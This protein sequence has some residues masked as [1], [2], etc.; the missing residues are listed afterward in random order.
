MLQCWVEDLG[1]QNGVLV[2]TVEDLE[3]EA[4]RRV[5]LLQHELDKMAVLTRE[6]CVALKDHQVEVSL[7]DSSSRAS[8]RPSSSSQ[9]EGSLKATRD[10]FVSLLFLRLSFQGL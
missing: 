5:A 7:R 3:R 9:K 1:E 6:S 10:T 4:G 2:S 8:G